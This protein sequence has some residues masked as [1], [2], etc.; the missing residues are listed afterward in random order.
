MGGVKDL[1]DPTHSLLS[2]YEFESK[3]KLG[4]QDLEAVIENITRLPAVEAKTYEII[5]ALSMKEGVRNIGVQALKLG[6]LRHRQSS[7]LDGEKLRCVC[8][9]VEGHIGSL[10]FLAVSAIIAWLI[11]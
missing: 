3:L 1:S 8:A 7:Q 11:C 6:I 4:H 9:C 5:A 10:S 2:L